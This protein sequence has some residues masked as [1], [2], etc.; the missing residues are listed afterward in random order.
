ME[1][2]ACQQVADEFVQRL[3]GPVARVG[4]VLAPSAV[5]VGTETLNAVFE[6]HH[7]DLIQDYLYCRDEN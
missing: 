6:G 1:H 2:L 7:S 5:E 4:W 3:V